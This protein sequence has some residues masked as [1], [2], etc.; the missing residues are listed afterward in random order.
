MGIPVDKLNRDAAHSFK[1]NYKFN[2]LFEIELDFLR[3]KFNKHCSFL[4]EKYFPQ[5]TLNDFLNTY[6]PR[7]DK[8]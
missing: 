6:P 5:L 8:E 4:M 1:A 7:V 3:E 2:I